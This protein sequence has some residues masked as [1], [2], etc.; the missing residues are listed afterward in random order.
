MSFHCSICPRATVD[1]LICI[2]AVRHFLVLIGVLTFEIALSQEQ[3]KEVLNELTVDRPGM[4]DKP[5]TVPKGTYQI[6]LGFDYFDR[7]D[8]KLYNLPAGLLRTG[9][10]KRT[11]LRIGNRHVIDRTDGSSFSGSGPV[12]VGFK[13]HVV[14]QNKR[15]PEIDIAAN[16]VIPTNDAPSH[17]ETMGY[18]FLLL[19]Q[20]DFYPNMA[21]NYNAGFIWDQIH[22]RPEFTASFCFDYL[23]SPRVGLFLEYFMFVP[24]R[25]QGEHGIDSGITYK[26]G[27]RFQLDLSA[28]ISRHETQ[29]NMF[30]SSG[31]TAMIN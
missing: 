26:L 8:G 21:L 6:E 20:N 27:T 5:F 9:I 31:V 1:R 29:N 11:E 10:S 14:K 30:I 18:E 24:S 4:A 15:I 25:W 13:S 7:H 17:P 28:G 23:P 12:S 19:F 2:V 22:G 3:E 16:L